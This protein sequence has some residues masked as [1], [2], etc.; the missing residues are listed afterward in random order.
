MTKETFVD[1]WQYDKK[2]HL[3]SIEHIFPQG[4]NIP[5]AWVSMIADGDI[6][7]ANLYREDYAHTIGNLTISGFNSTLSNKSFEDKRDRV[8]NSGNYVG[9]KNGLKLN[10]DLKDETSWTI[11]KIKSRTEKLV[12]QTMKLFSLT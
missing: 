8:N 7:K 11:E 9:Y 5:Q 6:S 4:E 10:E 1:L 2:Q 3:W 12:T